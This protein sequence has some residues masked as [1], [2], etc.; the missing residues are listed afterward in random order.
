[1]CGCMLSVYCMFLDIAIAPGQAGMCV[2]ACAC[3]VCVAGQARV[4]VSRIDCCVGVAW[5]S[6][7]CCTRAEL[8]TVAHGDCTVALHKCG[9]ACQAVKPQTTAYA[10]M[11]GIVL[12]MLLAAMCLA[13]SSVPLYV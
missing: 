2:S 5:Q 13:H 9:A 12:S 7:V 3:R 1:M 8:C 4:T 10:R 11:H 6:H